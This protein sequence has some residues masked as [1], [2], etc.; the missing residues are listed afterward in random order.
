MGEAQHLPV[1]VYEGDGRLMVAAPMPGLEPQDISV[2][3][4]G[5]RV[6]IHGALRGPHQEDRDPSVAEWAIGPYHRDLTLP[7]SVDGARA[8]ATYG[9]GVLVLVLPKAPR[10]GRGTQFTLDVLTPTRGAHVGHAGRDLHKS[11]AAAHRRTQEHATAQARRGTK[12]SDAGQRS[13][14]E[15]VNI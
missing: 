5:D 11:T 2:A 9:N 4:K 13:A 1:R 10:G 12:A 14:R 8:N 7:Q 3:V 6:T 15:I